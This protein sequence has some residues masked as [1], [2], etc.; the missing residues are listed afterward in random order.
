MF[1]STFYEMP[2]IVTGSLGLI[3]VG[4]SFISSLIEN[5]KNS[6]EYHLE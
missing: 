1:I 3:F 4:S 6:H 2:E 5:K